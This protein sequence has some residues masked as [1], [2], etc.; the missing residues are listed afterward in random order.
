METEEDENQEEQRQD[1]GSSTENESNVTSSFQWFSL[2]DGV[3]ET[4]RL[5]W[6]EVWMMNIYEFF[7][8]VSYRN[9]KFE[10]QKEQINKWKQ[11]H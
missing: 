11:K 9:E 1:S 3:S 6:N 2:V 8:I 4:T 5:N 10:R 7:N